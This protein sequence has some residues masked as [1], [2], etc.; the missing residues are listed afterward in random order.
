M[1]I[2]TEYCRN[3]ISEYENISTQL[4][5]PQVSS[6]PPEFKKLSIKLSE[7]EPLQKLAQDFLNAEQEINDAQELLQG[8]NTPEMTEFYNNSI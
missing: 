3:I 2:N 1:E 5:S 7:L 8:E 6:N 4:A